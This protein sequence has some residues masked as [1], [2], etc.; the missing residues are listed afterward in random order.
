MVPSGHDGSQ[1]GE[2]SASIALAEQR[3]PF[4]SQMDGS[5]DPY[6]ANRV[7]DEHEQSYRKTKKRVIEAISS[8][9]GPAAN[10]AH[11]VLFVGV[12]LLQF[13]PVPALDV[14]GKVLLSI[15]DAV[16]MIKSNRL[17]CLRLAE[18]CAELLL[19]I[20]EDIPRASVDVAEE[21]RGPISRLH[22]AFE[23][24]ND[25]LRRLADLP[26][27]LCYVK[28]E[29]VER[30]ISH[31][32]TL[33]D[34]ARSFFNL[35]VQMRI[36]RLSLANEARNQEG[37]GPDNVQPISVEPPAA[38]ALSAPQD[39]D[40]MQDITEVR[41]SLSIH[42]DTQDSS[43]NSRDMA[44][45]R[46]LLHSA[47]QTA[48]DAAML[49]VLQ[50]G[51]GEMPEAIKVLQ[52]TL[53]RE[54]QLEQPLP[55]GSSRSPETESQAV[56]NDNARSL[57]LEFIGTILKALRR[58]G[59]KGKPSSYRKTLPIPRHCTTPINRLRALIIGIDKYESRQLLNLQGA[60]ADANAVY[61][62]LR[63]ELLVPDSQIVLLRNKQARRRDILRE[64]QALGISGA[65]HGFREGDPILIYFAG[66]GTTAKSPDDWPT[67]GQVI[68]LIVPYDANLNFE[69]L[70]DLPVDMR[71]RR[72]YVKRIY[73]I[74]D[75]T[76]S[77]LLRMLAE[78]C[79]DNI[80]L[81]LD[82][83]HSASGTRGSGDELRE[84]GVFIDDCES[85]PS[86]LDEEIW[87]EVSLGRAAGVTEGFGRSGTRSHVLLAACREGEVARELKSGIFTHG[88]LDALRK[89]NV[90]SITYTELVSG[91]PHP[92]N[93]TPQCEGYNSGR[94]LFHALVPSGGHTVY[95]VVQRDGVFTMDAGSLHGVTD[96]AQ[97]SIHPRA[98]D[99]SQTLAVMTPVSIGSFSSTL[100]LI[101]IY[102]ALPSPC[103]AVP[104]P[105]LTTAL[106]LRI[107]SPASPCA[108]FET[109]R[110]EIRGKRIK[111][112]VSVDVKIAHLGLALRGNRV[113]YLIYYAEL[114][115]HGHDKLWITT[116]LDT[117]FIHSV[118]RAASHFFWHL[119][120]EPTTHQLWG[121]VAIELYTLRVDERGELDRNLRHPYRVHSGNLLDRQD[122]V[123]DVVADDSTVY[124]IS[125]QNT[126]T[127]ALHVWAFYFDCS[128]LS[129]MDYYM[130]PAVA[131]AGAEPPL[132]P[133]G[134]LTIGYGAGG[135]LPFKYHLQPGQDK[136]VGII[137]MFLSTEAV[138]LG[139]ILQLAPCTS[140]LVLPIPDSRTR[141]SSKDA[142]SETSVS[143]D[144]FDI[145]VRQS[146]PK[147]M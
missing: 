34:D 28:R 131:I 84:R 129:I 134:S 5:R 79:G 16:E 51:R 54:T 20:R 88:F 111:Y 66:Y 61:G 44:D 109:L 99:T 75:R 27:W 65:R 21:L 42:R 50:M 135:V 106:G 87:S 125:L 116:I 86:D 147:V 101:S 62:Y 14:A 6:R 90:G 94:I 56:V 11:E 12:D 126:S 127:R 74:P 115:K 104:T 145:V 30:D 120:R 60:V 121:D 143:W 8:V 4:T 25:S 2:G 49:E 41:R 112:S 22:T 76:I 67:S 113:E 91:I 39:I 92:P 64:I 89:F 57:D 73:P 31:C 78:F 45:L 124:G 139:H 85:I 9:L 133:L 72:D 146:R 82:C 18:R 102:A 40:E 35:Q 47:L 1:R 118:L 96:D 144:T 15:W 19:A 117:A 98:C 48:D 7:F 69:A 136:D 128:D 103:F 108:V 46:R 26:L 105:S 58:L 130:P 80:T 140:E 13:V 38:D 97:F 110:R 53:G 137:R 43:D 23:N 93:Q 70:D 100:R 83:C 132:P 29:D 71:A 24:I 63:N 119:R 36:L 141:G 37:E 138:E 3:T 122:P 17:A 59:A 32:G 142:P 33:L 95:R 10:F 52:R 77:A 114:L 68:S 81:I 107:I 55:S 123:L